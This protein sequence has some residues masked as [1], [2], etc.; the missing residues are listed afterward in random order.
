VVDVPH[1]VSL[2][3]FLDAKDFSAAYGIACLGVTVADWRLL[4]LTAAQNMALEVAHKASVR[5]KDM[6]FIELLSSIKQRR[7]QQMLLDK[8][9]AMTS[10]IDAKSGKLAS[11]VNQPE[12]KDGALSLPRDAVRSSL[13]IPE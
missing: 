1:S 5:T 9:D 2:Y 7:E 4:A 10:K 8:H 6:A 12:L 3:R 11:D 13:R